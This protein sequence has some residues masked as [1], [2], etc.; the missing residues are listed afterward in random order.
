VQGSAARN[1]PVGQDEDGHDGVDVLLDL[2]GDTL[3][4]ELVLLDTMSVGQSR[5]VEDANLGKRLCPLNTFTIVGTYHNAV[6]AC[7]FVKARRFGLALI[8][9]TSFLVGMIENVDVVMTSIVA[10]KDIGDEFQ[11]RRFS[12]TSLISPTR[13]M[14]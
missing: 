1:G 9:R 5:R 6:L 4:E 14:V 13:R 7:E 10:G 8:I 11:E 3:S 2:S 12:D